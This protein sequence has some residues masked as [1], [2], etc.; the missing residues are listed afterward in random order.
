MGKRK[1]LQK[2]RK[3]L[4]GKKEKNPIQRKE[5][6]RRTP[7]VRK[8]KL[9]L[10]ETMEILKRRQNQIL[11]RKKEKKKKEDR[12]VKRREDGRVKRRENIEVNL[13]MEETRRPAQT[14]RQ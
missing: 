6:K 2:S 12:G 9:A 4:N 13:L 11:R 3:K 14:R 1:R 5:L 7:G 10:K 8:E